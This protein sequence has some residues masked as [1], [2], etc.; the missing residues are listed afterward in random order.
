[1]PQALE[2]LA[3]WPV[4]NG[5]VFLMR[6]LGLAYNEAVVTLLDHP[7]SYPLLRRFTALLGGTTSLALLLI[8]ATP[9]AGLWFEQFSGLSSRLGELA[10]GS[11]WLFVLSPALAALQSWYQG[12]L[13]N[14]RQTRAIT[15]SVVVFMVVC[16]GLLAA[17]VAWGALPGVM[18]AGAA[19]TIALAAQTAWQALR[20]RPQRQI[21]AQRDA[22]PS[23]SAPAFS[24]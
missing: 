14:A 11:L 2:S 19:Y 3:V 22:A 7:R 12:T 21:Y 4:I 16:V 10:R 5:L 13:L 15:E 17:G 23:P 18:L 24:D 9:L 20:S 1:M 8:S 6:S